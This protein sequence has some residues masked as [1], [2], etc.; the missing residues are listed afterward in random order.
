[1]RSVRPLF[2]VLALTV[3]LA[4]CSGFKSVTPE[5]R[6]TVIVRDHTLTSAVAYDRFMRW[7]AQTYNSAQDVIQYQD[8][9]SGSVILKG[10]H[11]VNRGGALGAQIPLTYTLTA[12]VRDSRIRFSYEVG[13]IA[14]GSPK[15]MRGPFSGDVEKMN[16]FFDSLTNSAM[17][18]LGSTDDF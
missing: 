4:G 13:G 18:A 7:A 16:L 5:Q 2:A 3:T 9:P 12:D 17:E 11:S 1:M 14:P 15:T 6:S 10:I 8:K